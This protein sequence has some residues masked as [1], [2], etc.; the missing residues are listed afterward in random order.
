MYTHLILTE[1]QNKP[2]SSLKMWVTSDKHSSGT[3]SAV[4]ASLA[5]TDA[6]AAITPAITAKHSPHV[7]PPNIS[8]VHVDIQQ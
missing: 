7:W 6:K 1:S 2:M 8:S 3:T 4:T 5:D